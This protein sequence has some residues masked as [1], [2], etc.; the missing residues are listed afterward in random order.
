MDW[1]FNGLGLEK[2]SIER[3][4]CVFNVLKA[5]FKKDGFLFGG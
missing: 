3:L 2:Q 4:K 5:V 1:S